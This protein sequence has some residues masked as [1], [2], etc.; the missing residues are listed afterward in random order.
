MK[1][2]I[3]MNQ[4][5]TLVCLEY[6]VDWRNASGGGGEIHNAMYELKIE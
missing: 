5:K 4:T 1:K 3:R 2:V 6:L